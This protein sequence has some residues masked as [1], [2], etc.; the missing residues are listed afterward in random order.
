MSALVCVGLRLKKALNFFRQ[1][2]ILDMPP[3][4]LIP[5]LKTAELVHVDKFPS[6]GYEER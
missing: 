5:W 6:M 1:V 3:N 4:L 2:Q